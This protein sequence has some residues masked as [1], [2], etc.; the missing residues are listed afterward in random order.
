MDDKENA[1]RKKTNKKALVAILITVLMT[2]SF[3]LGYFTNFFARGERNDKFDEIIKITDD[4]GIASEDLSADDIAEALKNAILKNDKY[5]EYYTAEEYEA[6]TKNDAGQYVGFGFSVIFNNEGLSEDIKIGEILSVVWNS[7]AFNC[8]M[9]KGDVLI[10]GYVHETYFPFKTEDKTFAE[11]FAEFYKEIEKDD[12]ITFIA[13]RGEEEI[14][15]TLKKEVYEASYVLYAD[16]QK[17]LKFATVDGHVKGVETDEAITALADDSAYIKLTAFEGGAAKQFKEA[18]EFMKE[19]GRTK[20]VLD[21]R[22]NGGGL[23][24][25]LSDIA[26]YII[27][28]N[29]KSRILLMNVEEKN[30]KSQYYTSSNNFYKDLTAVSVIANYN[31]ASASECLLGALIAYGNPDVYHGAAFSYSNLVITAKHPE[32]N[33][34]STYGKGIMQ[35]TYLLKSGGALKLTTAKIYWP[36]GYASTCIHDVGVIQTDSKNQVK[37]ED[38][39]SRAA[40]ILAGY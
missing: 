33:T 17:G 31:T 27:N 40:E 18:I 32:R 24:S 29:D 19:R 25:V 16:N 9:K 6:I 8:G 1:Q 26:S 2:V 4:Y 23:L 3:F 28:D 14:R 10:G 22:D 21:L 12:E 5:A 30:R 11:N 36:A 38:A 37:D 39:I 20:L 15:L 13:E 35:T 7:P 34:Y